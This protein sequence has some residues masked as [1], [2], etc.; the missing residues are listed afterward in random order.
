MIPLQSNHNPITII[1]PFYPMLYLPGSIFRYL[2]E[3]SAR[4]FLCHHH[5]QGGSSWMIPPEKWSNNL[6]SEKCSQIG[7]LFI[8][9]TRKL[10]K[11]CTMSGTFTTM[12]LLD[13]HHMP[14]CDFTY[15]TWHTY[16]TYR[17]IYLSQLV[18]FHGYV[19]HQQRVASVP[20][21][22]LGHKRIRRSAER[23]G[24]HQEVLGIRLDLLGL[25]G[26][27]NTLLGQEKS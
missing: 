4:L 21:P 10:M 14:F 19:F 16:H 26:D 24:A 5:P 23:Q 18:I 9:M 7:F 22:L 20:S 13:I 11:L 27:E 15:R 6:L 17:W 2:L 1:V 25:P 12:S 8:Q 3:P